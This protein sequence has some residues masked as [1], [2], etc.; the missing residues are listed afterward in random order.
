MKTMSCLLSVI[1][2][3][4][5]TLAE[6]EVVADLIRKANE[7]D[8]A[9][10]VEL[11]KIHSSGKDVPKN[12]KEALVWYS[13]AAEQGDVEAQLR[14]ATAYIRG[15]GVPKD[16]KEAAKW[17]LMAAEQGNSEAQCQMARMHMIGAGVPK[18]DILAYKWAD[19]AGIQGNVAAK[20][21]SM[22]LEKRM[23]PEQINE[24]RELRSLFQELSKLDLPEDTSPELDAPPL[25]PIEPG[26][27]EP[28][29]N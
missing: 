29:G 27:L 13:K 28:D 14:V 1:P 2:M 3:L 11:G 15:G 4:A 23:T 26:V 18:D 12:E 6:A 17:Y 25:E 7:G 24:A 8:I 21:I 20:N 10:Q 5:A 22:I 19:L 16:S 9:A